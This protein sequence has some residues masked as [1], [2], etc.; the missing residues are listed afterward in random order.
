[1]F[2]RRI[3]NGKGTGPVKL[4]EFAL[5]LGQTIGERPQSGR[6]HAHSDMAGKV[7]LDIFGGIGGT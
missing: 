4:P 6:V 5:G 3:C 7:Y 2:R 1:M